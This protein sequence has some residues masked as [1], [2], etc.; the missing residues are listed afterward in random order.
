MAKYILY[1][2]G[3][4]KAMGE[5][6]KAVKGLS[7]CGKLTPAKTATEKPKPIYKLANP[8]AMTFTQTV[9]NVIKGD[10][11]QFHAGNMPVEFE[12]SP[13]AG[14]FFWVNRRS[15]EKSEAYDEAEILALA[16]VR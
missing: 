7:L 11:G 8:L 9:K 13:N 16:K 1:F 5:A 15:S 2:E 4:E 12:L 3:D 14:V 10:D 6:I